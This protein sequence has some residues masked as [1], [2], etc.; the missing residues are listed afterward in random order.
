M[1]RKGYR[2]LKGKHPHAPGGTGA[3]GDQVPVN[4][5]VVEGRNETN[6]PRMEEFVDR[7][8][9]MLARRSHRDR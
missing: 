5:V 3:I 2:R 9:P 8:M 4:E 1:A 6:R 7:G